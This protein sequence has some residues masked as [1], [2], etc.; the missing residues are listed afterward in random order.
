MES[1]M[2]D[3]IMDH[4]DSNDMV[5][6]SQHVFIHGRS[7]LTNLLV[8]FEA[9]TELLH[10]SY[11]LDVIYL[12]YQKAFD[13]VSH[14]RLLMKLGNMGFTG[15]ILVWLEDFLLCRKM[16]VQVNGPYSGWLDVLSGVP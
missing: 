12:D 3:R 13:T 16:K 2:R 9:W 6:R 14:H 1:V 4:L 7:C 10:G 8:T 5:S 11:G 15:K